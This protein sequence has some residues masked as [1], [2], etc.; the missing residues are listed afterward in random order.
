MEEVSSASQVP[1]MST[2]Y[3]FSGLVV[4][5]FHLKILFASLIFFLV[6]HKLSWH[7]NEVADIIPLP[8]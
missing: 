4:I 3:L 6:Y 8:T 2:S 5:I 7:V 1:K